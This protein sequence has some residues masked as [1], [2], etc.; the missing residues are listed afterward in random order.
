[1]SDTP[2]N[3][4]DSFEQ[5]FNKS[6]EASR[7]FISEGSKIFRGLGNKDQASEFG[8]RSKAA[9]SN[10]FNEYV[11]LNIRHYSNLVDLS[12][13]FMRNLQAAPTAQE[14]QVEATKAGPGFVLE[15]DAKPGDTAQ[16]RFALDNIKDATVTCELIHS[17]FRLKSDNSLW[18][19][20]VTF[21]P[22]LFELKQNSSEAITISVSVPADAKPGQYVAKVQVK[23]FE[24]AYFALVLHVN[25]KDEKQLADASN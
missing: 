25:E 22:Q 9:L 11:K 7:T 15:A 16:L 19:F 20:P 1:M 23:G 17:D 8:G 24:P 4:S 5:L 12:L 14:E 18:D 21:E 6:I 10:A 2:G 3:V 13:D